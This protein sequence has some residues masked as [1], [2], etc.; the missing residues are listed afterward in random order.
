MRIQAGLPYCNLSLLHYIMILFSG[1]DF[2]ECWNRDSKIY[3]FRFFQSSFFT[4]VGHKEI[5]QMGRMYY[6]ESV[7]FNPC[8][9]TAG[10]FRSQ[11]PRAQE[12]RPEYSGQM[13]TQLYATFHTSSVA[14]NQED[15]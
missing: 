8:H 14:Y 4:I 9:A 6:L 12:L 10:I 5:P 1:E 11:S 7:F 3:Y 13:N 2:N 15:S